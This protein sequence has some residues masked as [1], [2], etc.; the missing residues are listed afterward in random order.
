[1]F[2]STD[3]HS[4]IYA[5]RSTEPPNG[6]GEIV[7]I[8]VLNLTPLSLVRLPR[9]YN[10][11]LWR[12][13]QGYLSSLAKVLIAL[14][15]VDDVDAAVIRLKNILNMVDLICNYDNLILH[16]NNFAFEWEESEPTTAESWY[17]VSI[18]DKFI[19]PTGDSRID[20]WDQLKRKRPCKISHLL[21][22]GVFELTIEA[23]NLNDVYLGVNR[24]LDATKGSHLF[25]P[26]IYDA[27]YSFKCL[28]S[29]VGPNTFTVA[30]FVSR[31]D[32][33]NILSTHSAID[34]WQQARQPF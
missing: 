13:N 7:S 4:E 23:S 3:K 10:K 12:I 5:I 26:H 34:S 32:L 8:K 2:N 21:S 19:R 24:L 27:Y 14:C 15:H 22:E 6:D 16:K 11:E 1:M 28:K 18:G 9:N 30:D 20:L 31:L 25:R 33:F 29:I 17:T